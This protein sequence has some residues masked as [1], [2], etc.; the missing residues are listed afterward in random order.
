[1]RKVL[2]VFGTRPE[3]IKLA[4]VVRA[5]RAADAFEVSV[6]ATGQ[7][8]EMLDQTLAFFK[9][10]S[11]YDLNLM[12]P[13]QSLSALAAAALQTLPPVLEELRPEWMIVQG[14]TSTAMAAAIA[15]YHQRIRVAHVEAGLRTGNRYAPFPEELNRRIISTVAE[16]HFAPT[17]AARDALIAEGHAAASIEVTGNTGIDALFWVVDEV[18]QGRVRVPCDIE[19]ALDGKRL[20]LVTTHRRESFE[21]GIAEIC[22]ALKEIVSKHEDVAAV[23]PVHPNPKV[24]RPVERVLAGAPRIHLVEPLD[25]GPFVALLDRSHVVLTDSGGIQEETTALGKPTLVLRET[26]ERPEAIAAGT[27][28]LAGTRREVIVSQA[29]KLLTDAELYARMAKPSNVF[30]DGHAAT[31]I[32]ERLQAVS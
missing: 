18:R 7:H 3:A 15:G 23:L 16:L 22:E 24:K 27:A 13:N 10:T 8:R 6:C 32:A 9:L 2:V 30:G 14:D 25:Y 29:A 21:T 19:A 28:L 26:T 31:R 4:P 17:D 11:D 5:L 1:M 12:A 20:L